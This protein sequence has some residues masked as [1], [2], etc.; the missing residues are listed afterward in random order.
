MVKYYSGKMAETMAGGDKE[1]LV[2]KT[3]CFP[4]KNVER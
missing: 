4:A 1:A 3:L 2:V